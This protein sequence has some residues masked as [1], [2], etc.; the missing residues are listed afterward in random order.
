MW[1]ILASGIALITGIYVKYNYITKIQTPNS[2]P[3]F[4]FN[5]EQLYEIQENLEQAEFGETL[6][7]E[8]SELL[9]QDFETLL[10]HDQ[11]AEFENEIQELNEEFTRQLSDL[12]NSSIANSGLDFYTILQ[13]IEWIC[14]L[15]NQLF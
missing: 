5:P 7:P 10:G 2:P 13:I 14:D 8:T 9:D 3:T 12:L 6:D 11:Y 1:Y 15:I 4:N